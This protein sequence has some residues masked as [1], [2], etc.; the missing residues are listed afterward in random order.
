M[1]YALPVKDKSLDAEVDD[2][3]ARAAFFVIYDSDTEEAEFFEN[4]GTQAHGA[5][6]K[7][8]ETLASKGA[9]VL[10]AKNVGQNAFS[11]LKQVGMKVLIAKE[12][13][14]R[15]NIESAMNGDLSALETP[16]PSHG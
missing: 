6:P 3:F 14:A 16:G 7:M 8:V 2:R 9:E 12:G 11:A 13:T 15:E 4:E 10:I 5:G 1:K